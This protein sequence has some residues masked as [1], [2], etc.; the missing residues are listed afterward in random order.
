[1]SNLLFLNSYSK[2]KIWPN[3]ILKNKNGAVLVWFALMVT[4]L[5]AFLAIAIDV[6]Y[7]Y[8]TRNEL[9]NVADAA[10]LAGC[11][12]LG[13]IYLKAGTVLTGHDVS[14]AEEDAI[15]KAATD[16]AVKNK[17]AGEDIV[18]KGTDIIIGQWNWVKNAA[19]PNP[20]PTNIEPD[21][22]QVTAYRAAGYSGGAV[23]TFFARI[24]NFFG[25]N[26]DFFEASAV[27]TAALSGPSS[28]A[29]GELI[30]PMGIASSHFPTNCTEIINFSP[31]TGSCAGWHNWFDSS[32]SA[33]I[34]ARAYKLIES[35]PDGPKWLTDYWNKWS[36]NQTKAPTVASPA[37]DQGD[38][39]SFTGGQGASFLGGDRIQW[40]GDNNNVFVGYMDKDGTPITNLNTIKDP[41]PFPALFDFYRMRDGDGDDRI[42][43]ASIPVYSDD[44]C[45]NPN[46]TIRILGFAKI[47]VIE[48]IPPPN[49]NLHVQ[50]ECK[51][52]VDE[53]RSGGGNYG[54]L[55]GSI[56]NLV[57]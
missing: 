11:G 39:I 27:A 8:A 12:E 41:A 38:N 23:A 53:G 19:K 49:S 18:I 7:M 26:H 48:S 32:D 55:K 40:S 57:E 25:G 28:M 4:C 31:T 35:H 54:N 29:E 50:I 15:K 16:V 37:V 13:R 56:P 47:K 9:Q 33:A 10:A 51:F 43:T 5:M 3:S 17:A 24:L 36:I 6:G 1:M 2:V 21:A 34:A 22:V 44:A 42:W 45:I 52:F 46:Q 20:N 14:G 30:T